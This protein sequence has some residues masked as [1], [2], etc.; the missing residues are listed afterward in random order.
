MCDVESNPMLWC[1]DED[2]IKLCV[3]PVTRRGPQDRSEPPRVFFS[4]RLLSRSSLIRWLLRTFFHGKTTAAGRGFDVSRPA[5]DFHI[6][7]RHA[8]RAASMSCRPAARLLLGLCR[9]PSRL[10]P[11]GRPLS[12]AIR[13]PWAL[14]RTASTCDALSSRRAAEDGVD[15]AHPSRR[16]RLG[17][18]SARATAAD[19]SWASSMASPAWG[20][21]GGSR[22]WRGDDA[23]DEPYD[24]PMAPTQR[25]KRAESHRRGIGGHITS[26]WMTHPF[27]PEMHE[28]PLA[29]A[30]IDEDSAG[31]R[32]R[33]KKECGGGKGTFGGGKEEEE[34]EEER[35]PLSRDERKDEGEKGESISTEKSKP[36]E[37][38]GEEG[39]SSSNT[40]AAGSS[41]SVS[42]RD[43]DGKDWG[44][45]GHTVH[46]DEE[47]EKS[48]EDKDVKVTVMRPSLWIIPGIA[49]R[50]MRTRFDLWWIINRIDPYFD[51]TDFLVNAVTAHGVVMERFGENNLNAL[52]PMLSEKVYNAFRDTWI[53]YDRLNYGRRGHEYGT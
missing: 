4:A 1:V 45:H 22:G 2:I 31:M 29:L 36:R 3:K 11:H 35:V 13:A 16:H 52:K 43:G 10:H 24:G 14:C 5:L 39:V 49:L 34:E 38:E 37:E 15:A 50:F 17:R 33:V 26:S 53:E 25:G 32:K 44:D 23:C 19:T 47:S 40:T 41:Q 51:E 18:F 6:A 7:S 42:H 28:R 8:R 20:A 30:S 9:G 46:A 12:V 27:R 21:R 48:R